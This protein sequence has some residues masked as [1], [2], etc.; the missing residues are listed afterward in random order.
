MKIKYLILL[1]VDNILFNHLCNA[2]LYL[3][4]SVAD[5]KLGKELSYERLEPLQIS[6]HWEYR[7]I[8]TF[9]DLI[10]ISLFDFIPFL[11]EKIFL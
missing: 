8:C 2:A 1:F 6:Y 5:L 3:L 4:S 9:H 7:Y 10:A 11:N